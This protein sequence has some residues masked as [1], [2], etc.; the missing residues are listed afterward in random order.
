MPATGSAPGGQGQGTVISPCVP[1]TAIG[2]ASASAAV[3]V[4]VSTFTPFVAPA[5]IWNMHAYRSLSGTVKA[6]AAPMM[7]TRSSFAS[8]GEDGWLAIAALPKGLS[9]PMSGLMVQS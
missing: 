6:L 9:G 7:P 8:G 1:L 2:L 4:L 5:W 3:G